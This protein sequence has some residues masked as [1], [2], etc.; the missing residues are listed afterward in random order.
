VIDEKSLRATFKDE[1]AA[2][3]E[4]ARRYSVLDPPTD[5]SFDRIALIAAQ[6]FGA[7]IAT[8]TIVDEDRVW[9]RGRLGVEVAEVTRG[10]GLCA[11][12]IL[13]DELTILSDTRL[14]PEALNNP[15][16]RDALGIRFYAAAPIVT[17]DSHRL[18]TVNVMDTKPRSVSPSQGE[19]LRALAANVAN[20]LELR[21]SARRA[22]ELQNEL[23]E[24]AIEDRRRSER[25][26]DSLLR[27]LL[28]PR[29][30]EIPGLQLASDYRPAAQA[31]IA[32]DFY[33]VFPIGDGRWGIIVGDVVGK[34]S[35]AGATASLVRTTLRSAL[36]AGHPCK[37]AIEILNRVMLL[38]QRDGELHFCTCVCGI[39]EQEGDAFR[40]RTSNG[41]HPQPLILRNEGAVEEIEGG[42]ILVGC[43]GDAQFQPR[44]TVLRRG[45]VVLVYTDG[46]TEAR[47]GDE[48]FG[49]AGLRQF[50]LKQAGASAREIVRSIAT[51]LERAGAVVRDDVALLGISVD[52]AIAG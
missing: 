8:V 21:L 17:R 44:E 2:R 10:P 13:T 47:I 28:P 20:E 37:D 7:P 40:L 24:R 45:D 26:A 41:G 34:G 1:E 25:E 23:L 43:L 46:L 27:R 30:P 48:M 16:V 31:S 3:L 35:E 39:L 52:P 19:I 51:E 5:G 38:D 33:D 22:V 9:L 42:G 50:L 14:D 32:G 36:V 6:A 29:L 12:A 11:S 18:G 15:L 4:A 49:E